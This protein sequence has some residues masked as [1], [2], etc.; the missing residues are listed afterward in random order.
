MKKFIAPVV[1][2]LTLLPGYAMAAVPEV[3]NIWSG[4]RCGGAV[5][6]T[7]GPL[8]PCD[9]C[10]GLVV[11]SNIIQFLL[12]FAVTLS[13]GMIVY[14]GLLMMVAAGNE[15]RFAEGKKKITGAVTG[16]AIALSA[17]AIVNTVLTFL[18][19]NPSFPWSN[20]TCG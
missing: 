12:Y 16:L 17:W 2:F 11:T 4:A 9:F 14:G 10:D 7:G 6:T 1:A 13:V 18:S 8:G 3:L 15:S 5:I 20:I 19:G